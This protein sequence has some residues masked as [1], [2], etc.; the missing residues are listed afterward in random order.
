[1]NFFGSS[2]YVFGHSNGNIL[3]KNGTT[4]PKSFPSVGEQTGTKGIIGGLVLAGCI[5]NPPSNIVFRRSRKMN[6]L[7]D[8]WQQMPVI[9]LFLTAIVKV[10]L[11][12]VC[13]A[14]GWRGRPY[15]SSNIFRDLRRVCHGRIDE[16]S[17][18]HFPQ[19]WW[20]RPS[21][22]QYLTAPLITVCVLVLCFPLHGIVAVICSAAFAS[23][24]KKA[25]LKRSHKVN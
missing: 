25:L 5:Y 19:L 24:P 14:S 12:S 6:V 18:E 23:L 11:T 10:I 22:Q 20:H 3:S 7:M 8:S 16:T 13:I 1:M 17:T 21:P 4:I 15:F 9:I 2:L